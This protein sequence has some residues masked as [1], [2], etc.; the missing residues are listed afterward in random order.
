[1]YLGSEESGDLLNLAEGMQMLS[2]EE[3]DT[4]S[5]AFLENCF[6]SLGTYGSFGG[7]AGSAGTFGSAG[8]AGGSL[9]VGGVG[10]K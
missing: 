4:V 2:I 10:K 6:G 8:C 5:G 7:T 9:C 3:V 1:M